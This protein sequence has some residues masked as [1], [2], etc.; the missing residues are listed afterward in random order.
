ML[1]GAGDAVAVAVAVCLP[2]T[3]VLCFVSCLLSQLLLLLL[4]LLVVLQ[5]GPLAV[6]VVVV[7]VA[8]AIAFAFAARAFC[9]AVV[10]VVVV[11]VDAL[12][13]VVDGC[14]G[15]HPVYKYLCHS[16]SCASARSA[17]DDGGSPA[18]GAR[19]ALP[20]PLRPSVAAADAVVV[21]YDADACRP[22]GCVSSTSSSG[23]VCS[24]H[25]CCRCRSCC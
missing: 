15:S 20:P 1:Y 13:I 10:V 14:C 16:H 19:H 24:C 4:L 18:D 6:I 23:L 8:V 17:A 21:V 5:L 25:R 12:V 22:D 7:A 11:A 9:V 2:A 3:V